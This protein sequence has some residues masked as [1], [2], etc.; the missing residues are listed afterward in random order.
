MSFFLIGDSQPMLVDAF[1]SGNIDAYGGDTADFNVQ[2]SVVAEGTYGLESTASGR[3]G[4]AY[5][6]TLPRYPARGDTWRC[7]VQYTTGGQPSAWFCVDFGG[8]NLGGIH[9]GYYWEIDDS[10]RTLNMWEFDGSNY[11]RFILDEGIGSWTDQWLYV[12]VTH[13]DDGLDTMDL[14]L[15]QAD[16]TVVASGTGAPSNLNAETGGVQFRNRSSG[17]QYWDNWHF[18]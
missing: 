18:I 1:E 10:N 8:G 9:P 12:E 3:L 4:S 5:D 16:G 15:K 14:S 13:Y 2:T 7:D 6:T 11:N 17:N